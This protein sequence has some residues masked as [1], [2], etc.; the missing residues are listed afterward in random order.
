MIRTQI[1]EDQLRQGRLDAKTLD[2]L[3]CR[4]IEEGAHCP[5]FVSRAILTIVKEVFG[6]DPRHIHADLGVGQVKFLAVADDEPAGRPLEQCQ[7]V[8]IL[9]TLDAGEDDLQVRYQ[10]GVEGFRPP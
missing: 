10:Q 2:S 8:T 9:S 4:R 1:I 3:F 6:I 7:K 5:P